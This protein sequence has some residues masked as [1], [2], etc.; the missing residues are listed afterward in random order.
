MVAFRVAALI[1][2]IMIAARRELAKK[3]VKGLEHMTWRLLS[4]QGSATEPL[5]PSGRWS[6]VSLCSTSRE[7]EIK[8]QVKREIVLKQH[9][10]IMT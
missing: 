8:E 2:T 3:S 10:S 6:I 5:K 9:C 1:T 4:V 7:I